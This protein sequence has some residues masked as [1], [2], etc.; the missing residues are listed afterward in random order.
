M[1]GGVRFNRDKV[2]GNHGQFV[3]INRK[4]KWVG[5][6]GIDQPQA[7]DFARYKLEF[8]KIGVVFADGTL[9]EEAVH[10]AVD[11]GVLARRLIG[12]LMMLLAQSRVNVISARSCKYR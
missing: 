6:S 5:S 1:V 7:M 4:L 2:I 11:G 10:L 3:I 12:E 8:G 9:V